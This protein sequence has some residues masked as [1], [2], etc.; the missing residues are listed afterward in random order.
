MC[1][2]SPGRTPGL[3]WPQFS[4]SLGGYHKAIADA[5]VHKR[6]NRSVISQPRKEDDQLTLDRSPSRGMDRKVP[7]G[8]FDHMNIPDSR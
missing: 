5:E 1:E 8:T 7:E 6:G 4:V 3:P 2:L